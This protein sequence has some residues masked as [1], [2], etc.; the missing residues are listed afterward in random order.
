MTLKR[1]L[2]HIDSVS[3]SVNIPMMPQLIKPGITYHSCY[4]SMWKVICNSLDISYIHCLVHCQSCKKLQTNDDVIKWKH[5][6]HYWPFVRG[7]RWIPF[8]KASDVEVWCFLSSLPE[9]AVEKTIE[10]PVILRCHH[11][12]YDIAVMLIISYNAFFDSVCG[13]LT[14]EWADSMFLWKFMKV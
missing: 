13:L 10:R 6:P 4:T 9:Q 1:W 2:S 14:G 5:F 11:T 8:T 3:C 12:H 7:D